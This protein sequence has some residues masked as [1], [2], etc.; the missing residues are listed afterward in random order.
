MDPPGGPQW[1][2]LWL[3]WTKLIHLVVCLPELCQEARFCSLCS[4]V[5]EL[6]VSQFSLLEDGRD[7]FES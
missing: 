2:F 6:P 4:T 5:Q 1:V 3:W 7:A